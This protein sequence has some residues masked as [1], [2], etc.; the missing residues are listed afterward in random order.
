MA[1]MIRKQVY[2]EPTQEATLKKLAS[3][4]GITEAEVIRRAIDKQTGLLSP[5]VR[6]LEAWESEKQFMS[7]RMK[8]PSPR[9]K[10]KF[11]REDVYD[12][13]LMRYDR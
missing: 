4:L 12:E 6:N 5:G 13:R 9:S 11:R 10:R 7:K 1:Q 2:I 3:M 8:G